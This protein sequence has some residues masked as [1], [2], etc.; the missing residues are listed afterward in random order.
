MKLLSFK[1]PK[2]AVANPDTQRVEFSTNLLR[3][4]AELLGNAQGGMAVNF[5][6]LGMFQDLGLD[7]VHTEVESLRVSYNFGS[8]YNI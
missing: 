1:T 8:N 7:G 4:N 3:M 5:L 2:L 6:V